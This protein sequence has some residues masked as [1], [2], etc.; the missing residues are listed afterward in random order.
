MA[1]LNIHDDPMPSCAVG[2]ILSAFSSSQTPTAAIVIHQQQS[3]LATPAR[4]ACSRLSFSPDDMLIESSCRRQ[5]RVIWP[6]FRGRSVWK[7]LISQTYIDNLRPCWNA[8]LKQNRARRPLYL[9]CPEYAF[10]HVD[11]H[12]MSLILYI[13]QFNTHWLPRELSL[14]EIIQL[15]K[16]ADRYDLNH[17]LVGYLG[18]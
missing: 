3:D 5:R 1:A 18:H 7:M 11:P 17:I 4:S 10:E 9:G 12:A 15:A 13:A 2:S 8:A 6:I 14:M 16:L